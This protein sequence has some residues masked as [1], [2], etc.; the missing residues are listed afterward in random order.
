MMQPLCISKDPCITEEKGKLIKWGGGGVG[1]C[2]PEFWRFEDCKCSE[3]WR[4]G[5][6]SSSLKSW[7]WAG[8]SPDV[9]IKW[10]FR[11]LITCLTSIVNSSIYW[12]GTEL[13]PIF[14][15][16]K[17]GNLFNFFHKYILLF[18]VNENAYR[19]SYPYLPY[20]A[21]PLRERLKYSS[22]LAIS[23][24]FLVKEQSAKA[25]LKNGTHHIAFLP[26]TPFGNLLGETP[27]ETQTFFL[28]MFL[29]RSHDSSA[30]TRFFRNEVCSFRCSK[31]VKIWTRSI[32]L[33]SESSWGPIQPIS[34]LF[35]AF[36]DD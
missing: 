17:I 18:S 7:I 21:L 22:H 12:V 19:K 24:N 36:W 29:E 2:E 13:L 32:L 3:R 35:R 23:T 11:E 4:Q 5:E 1:V 26:W 31:S 8:L 9:L 6:S 10:Y 15:S 30:V 27:G 25:K 33:L 28:L 14:F 34:I 16:L 20:Y